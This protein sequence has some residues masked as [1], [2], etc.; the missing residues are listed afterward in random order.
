M[1]ERVVEM[2]EVDGERLTVKDEVKAPA[3][4]ICINVY[5]CGGLISH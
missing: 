2:E 5:V 4:P 3:Q 1:G